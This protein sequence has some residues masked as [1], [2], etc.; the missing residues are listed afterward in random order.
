[1]EDGLL[2]LAQKLG[3]KICFQAIRDGDELVQ[4]FP[5]ARIFVGSDGS[6]SVIRHSMFGNDL[7][8]QKDIQMTAEVKYEVEGP[9]KSLNYV[10]ETYPC[11]KLMH[12]VA[13]ESIGKPRDGKTPV[14]LRLLIDSEAHKTVADA[15]FKTPFYFPSHGH[16]CVISN[17]C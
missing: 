11:L 15:S 8:V 14:T 13:T 6:H 5:S 2:K 4:L 7:S 10:T 16:L 3:I 9:T 17:S 12:Y 1:M